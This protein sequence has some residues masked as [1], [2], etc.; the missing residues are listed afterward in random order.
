MDSDRRV[1]TFGRSP[2]PEYV[3][4]LIFDEPDMRTNS[5]KGRWKDLKMRWISPSQEKN[6]NWTSE[7]YSYIISHVH[8]AY[9][10]LG[11]FRVLWVHMAWHLNCVKKTILQLKHPSSF[12]LLFFHFFSFLF[13]FGMYPPWRNVVNLMMMVLKRTLLATLSSL[14]WWRRG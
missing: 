10:Y 8:R 7:Q 9:D 2:I 4:L 1:A 3:K 13:A 14:S 11:P 6:S 5:V 12:H